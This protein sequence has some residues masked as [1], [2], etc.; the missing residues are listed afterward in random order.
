MARSLRRLDPDE[1]V[2]RETYD[3][4]QVIRAGQRE[5]IDLAPRTCSSA[6]SSTTWPARRTWPACRAARTPPARQIRAPSKEHV[7]RSGARRGLFVKVEAWRAQGDYWSARRWSACAWTAGRS[8]TRASRGTAPAKRVRDPPGSATCCMRPEAEAF[9]FCAARAELVAQII[10]PALANGCVVL[11][12]RFTDS[13]LAYQGYGRGLDVAALRALNDLA[14]GGLTPDRTLLFDLPVDEGL[15]RRHAA[16]DAIT[17]LDAENVAFHERVAGGYRA[18]AA[19]EPGRW[20]VVDAGA[21][22][23]RVVE[24]AWV[25]A[26]PSIDAV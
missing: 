19:A 23:D 5:F 26:N 24:A 3:A 1:A 6:A 2:L 18:M 22:V 21:A 25:A 7:R 13:T 14:T 12:D 15:R 9:L 20:R 10:R 16:P 17:R 4:I 11:C 8:S